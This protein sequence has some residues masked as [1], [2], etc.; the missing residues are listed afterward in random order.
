VLF[1][2][3]AALLGII[4]AAA[5]IYLTEH[6]TGPAGGAYW[7]GLASMAIGVVLA[8]V[9]FSLARSSRGLLLG[10]AATPKTVETIRRAIMGH[11]NVVEVVEL[12]TMHLAPKQ[13]LINAH[14]NLRNNLK[15]DEIER[16]IEEIEGLIK[17]AEPKVGKI[18]LETARESESEIQ[19]PIPQHVG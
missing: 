15:T 9:A 8:I 5:G 13:I 6:H 4:I 18:F 7:D 11:R 14:I 17:Q 19:E 12:L 2:D 3:S 10:E 16:T 1:E